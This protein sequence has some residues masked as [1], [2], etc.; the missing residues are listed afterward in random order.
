M[1]TS[2]ADD[3]V[4]AEYHVQHKDP[5]DVRDPYMLY[6]KSKTSKGT[7]AIAAGTLVGYEV[8]IPKKYRLSEQGKGIAHVETKYTVQQNLAWAIKDRGNLIK[9]GLLPPVPDWVADLPPPPSPLPVI[10]Y[11]QRYPPASK[12]EQLGWVVDIPK[13]KSTR[14]TYKGKGALQEVCQSMHLTVCTH[15]LNL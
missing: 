13:A 5:N 11:V 2:F 6:I 8:A 10:S 4:L 14:A 3:A 9:P 7:S 1:I 15:M 12:G